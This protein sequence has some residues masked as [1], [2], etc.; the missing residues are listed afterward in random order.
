[1]S[2]MVPVFSVFNSGPFEGTQFWQTAVP[3]ESIHEYLS[4]WAGDKAVTIWV[5]ADNRKQI[6][7]NGAVPGVDINYVYTLPSELG[8]AIILHLFS[9]HRN[10]NP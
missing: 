6:V 2:A 10:G 5:N 1:M 9:Q 8:A 7:V 4:M 3:M